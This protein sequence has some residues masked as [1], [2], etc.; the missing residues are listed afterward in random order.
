MF[1]S[2]RN[3]FV[4]DNLNDKLFRITSNVYMSSEQWFFL[5]LLE[6][7]YLTLYYYTI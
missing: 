5:K 7:F 3:V 6:D 4:L 2:S 1:R